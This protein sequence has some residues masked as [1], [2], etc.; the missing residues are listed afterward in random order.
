MRLKQNLS[1]RLRRAGYHFKS[2]RMMLPAALLVYDVFIPLLAVYSIHKNGVTDQAFSDWRVY[3]CMFLPLFSVWCMLF[4]LRDYIESD[5]NE[6]LY[7]CRARGKLPD[8]VLLAL[9]FWLNLLALVAIGSAVFPAI[10]LELPRYLSACL[11]YFGLTYCMAY[12]TRSVTITLML[13]LTYTVGNV[14]V[15]VFRPVFPFYFGFEPLSMEV[16]LAVCLPLALCGVGL[17]ALGAWINHK[18]FKI[19]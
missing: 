9:P 7:V 6:L 16:G 13:V 2:V 15:G 17:A 10:W 12:L 14:L 8:M 5:G 4:A 18:K 19:V 11:W 1:G 3:I